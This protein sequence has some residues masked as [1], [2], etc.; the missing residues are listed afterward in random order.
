VPERKTLFTSAREAFRAALWII[1][2]GMAIAIVLAI[3]RFFQ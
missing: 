1:I 2:L 3:R